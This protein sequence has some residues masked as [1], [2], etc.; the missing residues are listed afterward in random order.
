MHHL[1]DGLP[2]KKQT[3]RTYDDEFGMLYTLHFSLLKDDMS[4]YAQQSRHV[5]APGLLFKA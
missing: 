4:E 3:P 5:L 1:P 2:P